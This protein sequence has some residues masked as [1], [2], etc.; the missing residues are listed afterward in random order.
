M[1]KVDRDRATN[2]KCR[3]GIDRI[4]KHCASTMG[5]LVVSSPR[6]QLLN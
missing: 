4:G 6:D 1:G 3:L 2:G 5:I